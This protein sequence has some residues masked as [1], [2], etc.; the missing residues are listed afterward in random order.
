MN[1]YRG[2]IMATQSTHGGILYAHYYS[3]VGW[4]R[5]GTQGDIDGD[6]C[7]WTWKMSGWWGDIVAIRSNR[8][9]ILYAHG[10]ASPQG[11]REGRG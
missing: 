1:R 2:D 8:G 5:G 10:E 11:N 9:V 3:H 7:A 4:N 6:A